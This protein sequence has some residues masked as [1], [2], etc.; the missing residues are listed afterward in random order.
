M[1]KRI[2]FNYNLPIKERFKRLS[3]YFSYRR[4]ARVA[5]NKRF[6]KLFLLHPSYNNP[7]EKSIEKAHKLYWKPFK[8]HVNLATARISKNI[9]G[10][11][12]PKYIPE[13]IFMADIE[14]TLNQTPQVE[15]LTF[16]SFYNHWFPGGIF[17]NDFIHNISGEWFN[18]QLKPIDFNDVISLAK[19]LNYPVVLKPNRDSYGG[20]DVYF[21]KNPEELLELVKESKDLIVQ[22]KIIQH[23]F[24]DQYNGN[25]L[26]TLRVYV[27]RSVL[28]NQLHIVNIVLRMGVGGSLDNET[29]GGILTLVRKDGFLNGFAVDKYGKNYVKHP[30]TGIDF[31]GKIPNFEG[32]IKLSLEIAQKIFYARL[33]GL[34]ICYDKDENWKMIEINTSG[35]AI[36]LAQY[37]GT[38]FF[39]EFSDEVYNYCVSKHWTLK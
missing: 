33:I 11:S 24:F 2:L 39:G 17:P 22:E 5:W 1:Y 30:D 37:H 34:D 19:G 23:S 16:K 9:S 8:S 6:K 26:N 35:A 14:P 38:L 7:L 13:E 15:F 27:Y 32:L 29:A 20:R 21:P 10:I 25:G 36:R 3:L 18:H 12:N 31:N 28:D 4:G